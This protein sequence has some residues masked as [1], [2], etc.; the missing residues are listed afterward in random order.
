M[1]GHVDIPQ[2]GQ[3]HGALDRCRFLVLQD[4]TVVLFPKALH[5]LDV[6]RYSPRGR[7]R[8]AQS[9]D[10]RGLR[11]RTSRPSRS[12]PDQPEESELMSMSPSGTVP[13]LWDGLVQQGLLPGAP[14]VRPGRWPD[15]G[16][17][18]VP[19]IPC[20]GYCLPHGTT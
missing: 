11:R 16:S 19:E 8:R 6:K 2:T 13:R 9:R 7:R 3:Q 18:A 10:C 1:V 4:P 17:C 12:N 14:Q 20:T 5:G 15:N